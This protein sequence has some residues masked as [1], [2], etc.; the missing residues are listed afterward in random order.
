MKTIIK[1]IGALTILSAIAVGQLRSALPNQSLP[2]NTRGLSHAI[3]VSLFDPSR[4]SMNHS[5]NLS[6]KIFAGQSLTMG[7]N[8]NHMNITMSYNHNIS[9]RETLHFENIIVNGDS[10]AFI[11]LETLF[12]LRTDL[13]DK[14]DYYDIFHTMLLPQISISVRGVNRPGVDLSFLGFRSGC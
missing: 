13:M 3:G 12:G 4:I 5:F 11:D 9:S 2:V 6:M 10:P 8:T 14:K 7:A 1:G